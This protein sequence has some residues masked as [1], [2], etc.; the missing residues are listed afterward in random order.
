M[1]FF[2]LS[3]RAIASL[4]L[5]EL[6][7]VA[8]RLPPPTAAQR[9]EQAI[10]FAYGNLAASTNHRATREQVEAAYDRAHPEGCACGSWSC[11]SYDPESL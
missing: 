6:L 3:P 9:R 2:D 4:T 8:K 5:E 11:A 1:K 10:S 7:D